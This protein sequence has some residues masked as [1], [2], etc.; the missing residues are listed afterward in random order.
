MAEGAVIFEEALATVLNQAEVLGTEK[1]LFMDSRGRVLAEDVLSDVDMPPFDK[2]AMD[3]YAC[4][5]EDLGR[6]LECIETI[7]AGHMP[8]KGVASG[9]CAKIMTGAVVPEGADTVIMV[10]DTEVLDNG[11]VRYHKESSKSNIAYKAEDVQKGDVVI[12]VNTLLDTKHIQTLAAV[13][14]TEVSVYRRPIVAVISTGEELVEPEQKPQPSQIRNSNAYSIMA[15]LHKMGLPAKHLGVCGDTVAQLRDKLQEAAQS[16]DVILFSGAVSMGDYDFVPRA[17]AEEG[18]EIFFHGVRAK[19]GQKTIFGRRGKQW[20]IG[21]PGNPV[22]SFVQVE[23]LLLPFLKKLMNA[24]DDA[25]SLRL[26]CSKGYSRRKGHLKQFLPAKILPDGSVERVAYHG[27][28]HLNSL[29]YANALIVVDRDVL[30]I[31]EGE[32]VDVRPI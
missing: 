15:Q 17:L 31:A 16:S 25:L 3:G 4:R 32:L 19:P 2:A 26:P 11:L 29:S 27:S 12:P 30:T 21:V 18:V 7:P 8:Q 20:F 23:F 22:S 24:R 14:Q 6:D 10:E 1:V 28:G 13:G 5:Q 9:Q